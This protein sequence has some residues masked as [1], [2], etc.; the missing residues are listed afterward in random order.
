[1]HSGSFNGDM[2]GFFNTAIGAS[3]DNEDISG[4]FNMASGGSFANEDVSGLFNHAVPNSLQPTFAEDVSG[5]LNTGNVIS[6]MFSLR[7]L[8]ANL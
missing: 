6:G 2:S 7:N 8:F 5:L 4:F 3:S 1:M